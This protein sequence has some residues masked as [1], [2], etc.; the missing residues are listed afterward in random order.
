MA[1]LQKKNQLRRKVV[2]FQVQKQLLVGGFTKTFIPGRDILQT[3]LPLPLGQTL[4]IFNICWPAQANCLFFCLYIQL[5][6]TKRHIFS[7]NFVE[8][9][10]GYYPGDPNAQNCFHTCHSQHHPR[11]AVL[12]HLS[13]FWVSLFFYVP[14]FLENH[15]IASH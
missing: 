13:H 15:S 8:T 6:F 7:G 11:E 1:N 2:M 10:G 12:A 5:Y 14:L 9:F 4:R 3:S